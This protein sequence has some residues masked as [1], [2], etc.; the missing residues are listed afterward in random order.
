M[1]ETRTANYLTVF[2]RGFTGVRIW[3]KSYA[4]KN[5]VKFCRKIANNRKCV[6]VHLLININYISWDIIWFAVL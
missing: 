6:Y 5:T 2:L 3:Q 1:N 4:G